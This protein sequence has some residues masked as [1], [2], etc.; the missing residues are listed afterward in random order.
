MFLLM[1]TYENQFE[2]KIVFTK[3]QNM[4]KQLSFYSPT[5]L[6]VFM[7]SIEEGWWDNFLYLQ[8][9]KCMGQS[10]KDFY[11]LGPC[12]IKCL[13]CRFNNYDELNSINVLGYSVLTLRH[14]NVYVSALFSCLGHVCKFA[15]RWKN[16]YR[17]GPL[18]NISKSQTILLLTKIFLIWGVNIH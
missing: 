9:E 6:I 15:L 7:F 5:F 18:C 10:Y 1:V 12:K 14:T 3:Y 8:R 13:N 11:P 2:I 4:Q 16:L 17:I